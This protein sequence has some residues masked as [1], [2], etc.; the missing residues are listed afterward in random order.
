MAGE[1]LGIAALWSV[2]LISL[3]IPVL[4]HVTGWQQDL[5]SFA[6]VEGQLGMLVVFLALTWTLAALGEEVAYRGFVFTRVRDVVGNGLAGTVAAVVLSSVLFGLVHTEQGAIGVI[7]TFFDAL[8]FS[9]LR[10]KYRTLWAAVLA[11]GFNNTIGLVTLY[12]V[13]PVHGLW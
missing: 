12:L 3:V 1:V 11:H 8:L 5:S 13:G 6:D 7:V 2:V 9:V 4:E 10:L